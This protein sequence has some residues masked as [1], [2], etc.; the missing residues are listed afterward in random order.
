M[1]V[2]MRTYVYEQYTAAHAYVRIRTIQCCTCIRTY[3]NNTLLHM[4]TDVYEQYSSGRL[5]TAEGKVI[6][7]SK[8]QHEDVFWAARGAGPNGGIIM[9]VLRQAYETCF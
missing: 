3:T 6:V 2:Y 9:Q 4:H 7:C 8:E 5:V 1:C